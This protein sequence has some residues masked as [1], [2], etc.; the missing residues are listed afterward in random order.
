MAVSLR[1]LMS[2]TCPTG[3]LS[4]LGLLGLSMLALPAVAAATPHRIHPL[5]VRGFQADTSTP[6]ATDLSTFAELRLRLA[7]LTRFRSTET[8]P[9]RRA[10]DEAEVA[11][12]ITGTRHTLQQLGMR[13]AGQ[14]RVA[15]LP[16]P[17]HLPSLLPPLRTDRSTVA[18]QQALEAQGYT[19]LPTTPEGAALW[20][21]PL[22]PETRLMAFIAPGAT[23]SASHLLQWLAAP[24][25]QALDWFQA[26]SAQQQSMRGAGE[27]VLNSEHRCLYGR[28]VFQRRV[29][30]S[31]GTQL[32]REDGQD[33]VLT[34]ESPGARAAFNAALAA[35]TTVTTVTTLKPGADPAL[36]DLSKRQRGTRVPGPQSV[37]CHPEFGSLLLPA[38]GQIGQPRAEFRQLWGGLEGGTWTVNG[39]RVQVQADYFKDQVEALTL[40][41]LPADE[42]AG[43]PPL[44][45][46]QAQAL[47][48]R[49]LGPISF[50]NDRDDAAGRPALDISVWRLGD[51]TGAVLSSRKGE[52]RVR[53]LVR[54]TR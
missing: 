43:H 28:F 17:A 25:T 33:A 3:L 22:A 53:P 5:C 47:L 19:R 12:S 29:Q 35:L 20:D 11:A 26:W 21:K 44:T 1:R 34:L 31:D 10:A 37:T 24:G 51:D 49:A 54:I 14:Q 32:T 8:D 13:I 52:A 15:A 41:V 30:F 45:H 16:L 6:Y 50:R 36:A 4:L 42:E 18:N 39:V 2:R 7:C 9:A 27:T 23:P 46:A 40:E 48:A 38:I